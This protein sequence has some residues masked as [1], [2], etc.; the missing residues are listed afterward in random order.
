[1]PVE[2]GVP[3]LAIDFD[4]PERYLYQ[5][6]FS[7]ASDSMYVVLTEYESDIWVMDLEW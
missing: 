1:M 2:G 5:W 4:D 3:S 7:A 6:G